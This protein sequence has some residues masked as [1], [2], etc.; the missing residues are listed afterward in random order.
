MTQDFRQPGRRV[1]MNISAAHSY[2][3]RNADFKMQIAGHL[4]GFSRQM[5]IDQLHL[6]PMEKCGGLADDSLMVHVPGVNLQDWN[7]VKIELREV[8]VVSRLIPEPVRT[9]QPQRQDSCVM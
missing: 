1:R 4:G 3:K 6:V 8:Y 9:A 7:L 2:G 5:R